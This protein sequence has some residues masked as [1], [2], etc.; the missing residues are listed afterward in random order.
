MAR[1]QMSSA[2]KDLNNNFNRDIA[3]AKTKRKKAAILAGG[4][5]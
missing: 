2:Y 1:K 5:Y 4:K 3:N